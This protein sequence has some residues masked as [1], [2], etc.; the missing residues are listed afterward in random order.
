MGL[1]WIYKLGRRLPKPVRALG[2]PLVNRYFYRSYPLVGILAGCRIRG[3][4]FVVAPYL[5]GDYE[6]EVCQTILQT[7]QPGWV[8]VD[9]GAH[10]GYF[11]LLFAK[12]VGKRGRVIA[13]EAHPLNAEM[14]RSNVRLNGYKA[15]VQVENMAVSDGVYHW[16]KVFPGRWRASNEW[17]IVGHDVEGNPTQPEL[18]I[19]ATSLDTYF[20]PGSHVDFIK[21][22]IEGA[23]A[24]A[25]CG[26]R[27]LLRESKP[28]MLVEFHD[29]AGWDGRQELFAAHYRL[30]DIRNTQWIDSELDTQRVYHCL[31]VPQERLADIRL[32]HKVPYP[33]HGMHRVLS[34]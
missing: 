6:P 22:D 1:R 14:L 3:G 15:Q 34:G 31:A 4:K 19:P 16:A 21:V 30:Y 28:L 7:V 13:F 27:R 20:S 8:C 23:E 18:E 17:N 25:L 24:Q 32:D 29:E 11:T 5:E 9:V 10:V 26:T 2:R 33:Q 12:L